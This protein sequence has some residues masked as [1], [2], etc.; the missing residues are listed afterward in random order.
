MLFINKKMK[1]SSGDFGIRQKMKIRLYFVT[2][3]LLQGL[4]FFF[5]KKSLEKKEFSKKK[6]VDFSQK[7]RDLTMKKQR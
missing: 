4:I 7:Q 3:L 1:R 6:N 2:T 5:L